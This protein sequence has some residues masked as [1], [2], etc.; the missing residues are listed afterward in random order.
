MSPVKQRVL[1]GVLV[2]LSAMTVSSTA[3]YNYEQKKITECQARFNDQ[4][5]QQLN[6][7]NKISESDRESLAQL[8]QTIVNST[9]RGATSKALEDY[10][11]TK[12]KNDAERKQ[13]PLPSLPQRSAHC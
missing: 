10:L 6:E 5:I 12:E 11:N 7:R 4:F 1:A 2:V 8:V 9:S 13:H 3:Y